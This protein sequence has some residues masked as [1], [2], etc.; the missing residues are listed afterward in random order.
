[1]IAHQTTELL[2]N[3]AVASGATSI[4]SPSAARKHQFLV[5]ISAAGTVTPEWSVD[6]T[7]WA[8]AS[9]PLTATGTVY[10]DGVYPYLR[11]SWA[12]NTGTITVDAVRT[13]D[14]PIGAR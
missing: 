14:D 8:A 9:D 4:T 13:D 10:L 7:R 11:L 5:A 1:M 6:G 2:I 3:T 12:G